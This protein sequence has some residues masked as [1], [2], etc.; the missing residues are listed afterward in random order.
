MFFSKTASEF[1]LWFS[2]LPLL[3]GFVLGLLMEDIGAVGDVNAC[4]KGW[5]VAD[6]MDKK[7]LS[8]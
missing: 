6:L 2:P 3:L 1:S 8:A 7:F 4:A 5:V